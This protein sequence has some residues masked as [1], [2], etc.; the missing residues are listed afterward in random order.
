MPGTVSGS[1]DIAVRK[2]SKN[3][4]SSWSLHSNEITSNGARILIYF[5]LIKPEN[6]TMNLIVTKESFFII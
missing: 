2:K 1:W 3:P 5:I 4:P 6:Y